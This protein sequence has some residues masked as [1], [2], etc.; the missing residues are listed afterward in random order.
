MKMKDRNRNQDTLYTRTR[1]FL[2]QILMR[3]EGLETMVFWMEVHIQLVSYIR[4]FG[5]GS[6]SLFRQEITLISFPNHQQRE[7]SFRPKNAA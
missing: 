1:C 7:Q 5:H 2:D 3:S 6:L 4:N